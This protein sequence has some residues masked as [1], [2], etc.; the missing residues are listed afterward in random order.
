MIRLVKA[1]VVTLALSLTTLYAGSGHNHDKGHG[2]SH[3]VHSKKEMSKESIKSIAE[4]EMKRLAS[5]K[6]IPNSWSSIKTLNIK[7]TGHHND[8]AVSFNNPSI[9]EKAEQTLYIFVGSNGD[10]KGANYSGK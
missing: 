8:W 9:Q 4:K 10:L 1:T 2:H 6:K 5:E 3:G 7:K